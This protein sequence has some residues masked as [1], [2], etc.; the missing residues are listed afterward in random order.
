MTETEHHDTGQ[1]RGGS[2]IAVVAL[3]L[4]LAHP[5]ALGPLAWMVDNG[6]LGPMDGPVLTVLEAI[7][8]PLQWLNDEFEFAG[9]AIDWYLSFWGR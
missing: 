4:L 5:L 8:Y 6:F 3:S 1:P 9:N 2:M 7:Y